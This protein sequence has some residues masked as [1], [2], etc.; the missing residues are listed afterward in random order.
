MIGCQ[1][2][3]KIRFMLSLRLLPFLG[4]PLVILHGTAMQAAVLTDDGTAVDADH[5]AVRVSLLDDGTCLVVKCWLPVGGVEHGA[6]DNQIVSIGG[7]QTVFSV[8]DGARH[9]QFQQTVGS[10]VD[11]AQ[12]LQFLFHELKLCVLLVLLVL[13]PYI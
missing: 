8:I 2:L 1:Y 4:E 7:R 13:A 10:S 11:S 9:G 12:G 5:L 6:V 3:D